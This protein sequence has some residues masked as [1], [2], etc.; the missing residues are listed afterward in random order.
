MM[1][2]GS[3]LPTGAFSVIYII[4]ILILH[5]CGKTGSKEVRSL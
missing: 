3:S 5:A 1:D 4:Y 2:G